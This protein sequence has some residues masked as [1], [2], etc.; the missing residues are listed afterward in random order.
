METVLLRMWPSG[1]PTE[2]LRGVVRH[3]ATGEE[4]VF[5]GED[6]L[7][8]FLRRVATGPD[9]PHRPGQS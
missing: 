1:E 5:Q 2:T 8:G 9:R 6:E 7:L 3:V 4:R